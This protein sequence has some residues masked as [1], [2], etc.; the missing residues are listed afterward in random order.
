MARFGGEE[1]MLL[2]PCADYAEAERCAERIRQGVERQSVQISDDV[3]IQVT[4]SMGVAQVKS[5]TESLEEAANRA[6]K[7]L[8]KAKSGGRNRVCCAT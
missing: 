1:F 5:A 4:V 7:A 6:D 8:Y 3:S 2:L